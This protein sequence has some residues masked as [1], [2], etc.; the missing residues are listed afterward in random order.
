MKLMTCRHHLHLNL[1]RY[2]HVMSMNLEHTILACALHPLLACVLSLPVLTLA[3]DTAEETFVEISDTDPEDLVGAAT[4][5]F[6]G[7]GEIYIITL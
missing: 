7:K 5:T 4:T 6:L 3:P 1:T 2:G